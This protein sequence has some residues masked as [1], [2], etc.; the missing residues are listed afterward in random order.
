MT[1]SVAEQQ[2]YATPTSLLPQ[3][4]FWFSSAPSELVLVLFSSLRAGS[5][6]L[7]LPQSWFWFSSP[8]SGLV[9][10][11][12]SSLTALCRVKSDSFN[13]SFGFGDN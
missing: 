3:S 8:L 13:T 11:L 1:P 6:S 9:L 4:W 7:L 10:V 5:G 12:F 2:K